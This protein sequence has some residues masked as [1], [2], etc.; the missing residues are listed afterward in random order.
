M[1]LESDSE[2]KTIISAIIIGD[3]DEVAHQEYHNAKIERQ[4]FQQQRT[5]LEIEQWAIEIEKQ[6]KENC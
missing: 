2:P 4:Y 6:T 1:K 3:D 5:M